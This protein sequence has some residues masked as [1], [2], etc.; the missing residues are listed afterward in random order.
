MRAIFE[1]N[2]RKSKRILQHLYTGPD[3]RPFYDTVKNMVDSIKEQEAQ[4]VNYDKIS[5]SLGKFTASFHDK[6]YPIWNELKTTPNPDF[7]ACEECVKHIKLKH[8][9]KHKK[10]LENSDASLWNFFERSVSE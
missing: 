2:P 3:T 10:F 6:F 5:G 1:S 7:G 9:Q 8:V 4:G